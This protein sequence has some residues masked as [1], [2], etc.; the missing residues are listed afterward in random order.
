MKIA[1]GYAGDGAGFFGDAEGRELRLLDHGLHVRRLDR[2]IAGDFC[3]KRDGRGSKGGGHGSA[4]EVFEI[5]GDD[6]GMS[7]GENVRIGGVA[8]F[9]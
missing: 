1:E 8:G 6:E 7:G 4:F 2:E 9:P 5:L 3:G